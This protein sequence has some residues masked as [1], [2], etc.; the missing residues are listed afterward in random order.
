MSVNMIQ[1]KDHQ[2]WLDN[3]KRIG[4][5]EASAILGLNPYMTNQ[6][7]WEIKTG[8]KQSEDISNKPYV[9]YGT[10]AEK[11]LRQMFKLDF[12]QYQVEYAD[13][14]MFLNDQYPFAHASLDGW[15]LDE[16]N[17]KGI[18]EIKTTEILKSMQKEKWNNQIP[19]NYYIRLIHYMMVTGFEYAVLKAQLKYDYGTPEDLFIQTKHYKVE[20]SEVEE[21]I[22]ILANKER[23][24]WEHVEADKKPPLMLPAI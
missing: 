6:E 12:P 21:D 20:R 2:E 24:F 4:G 3:R 17:R 9:K 19:D 18:L 16:D 15:L 14:N 11:Y 13:N 10:E 7:L 22:Q 23:E 8:R 5:S 1:L